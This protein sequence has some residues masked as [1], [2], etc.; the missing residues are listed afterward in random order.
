[1]C[2]LVVIHI[3]IVSYLIT[4]KMLYV[5]PN[6]ILLTLTGVM[7]YLLYLASGT[8]P[9]FDFESIKPMM[10]F[11]LPPII[12]NEVIALEK[13]IFLSNIFPLIYFGIIQTLTFV[14]ST[15]FITKTA[16]ASR[17]YFG[18]DDIIIDDR[19]L[20]IICTLL[21]M[22]DESG[23]QMLYTKDR[24]FNRFIKGTSLVNF[25][26]SISICFVM[27]FDI[28]TDPANSTGKN[29]FFIAKTGTLNLED[30]K[31]AGWTFL[32]TGAASLGIGIVSSFMLARIPI[33]RK[34][35]LSEILF[36]FFVVYMTSIV[37][38]LSTDEDY[39]S[40]EL[41]LVFFGI[42]SSH[43]TRYNLSL[44]AGSRMR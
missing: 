27:V 32:Y 4:K 44:E 16:L 37:G 38:F 7:A 8:T 31:V 34:S 11:I 35:V 29:D 13:D 17:Y 20:V 19:T 21:N 3:Y 41:I 6:L 42:F 15:F 18:I 43:Y 23:Y 30:L 5:H 24:R 1:M 26:V 14:A 33:L 39:I 2:I 10:R 9:H 12:I 28:E 25:I 36:F 40:E 22:G